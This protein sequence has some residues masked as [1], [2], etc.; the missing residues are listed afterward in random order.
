MPA[1]MRK[2]VTTL[3]SMKLLIVDDHP[4]LRAG[5]AACLQ[6]LGPDVEV[7]EAADA[8]Q[9]LAAVHAHADIAC[10]LMDLV[11]GARSGLEALRQLHGVRPRLPALMLS[12]SEDPGHVR[13]ALAA[14]ARGYCPKSAGYNTLVAALRVVL[15]GEV[16][17]P[18]LMASAAT[19]EYAVPVEAPLT[20]RQLEVLRLLCQ[21][22]P[23]K[24]IARKLATQE[25][26]VK[27]HVSAI[28][29]ALGVVNRAQA[30]RAA[31]LAG[32]VT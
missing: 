13:A 7:L 19:P 20:E 1:G 6:T 23:N 22:D 28:F 11:L 24:V 21:G 31:Q 15:A 16:Y 17:V 32:L 26:T 25:S 12:A 2:R 5:V 4:L 30:I 9:A 3:P 10:C 29:R 8:E 27:A 14:G 18:P